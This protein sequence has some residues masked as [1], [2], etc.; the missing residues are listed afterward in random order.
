MKPPSAKK[1]EAKKPVKQ[2]KPSAALA[3]LDLSLIVNTPRQ[4]NPPNKFTPGP[5]QVNKYSQSTLEK[6]EEVAAPAS[7]RG[8]TQTT[9]T[10]KQ[11]PPR[12]KTPVKKQAPAPVKKAK[13]PEKSKKVIPVVVPPSPAKKRDEKGKRKEEEKKVKK[14]AT[15]DKSPAPPA[16]KEEKTP[17]IKGKPEPPKKSPVKPIV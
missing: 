1:V 5:S 7:S 13:T 12:D 17:A 4:V 14:E 9:T 16:K 2:S 6:R 10:G 15:R 8:H 11:A 3:A